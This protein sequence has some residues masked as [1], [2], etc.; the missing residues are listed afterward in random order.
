MTVRGFEGASRPW[1]WL[2]TLATPIRW[3]MD[4]APAKG[5]GRLISTVATAFGYVPGWPSIVILGVPSGGSVA[6]DGTTIIARVAIAQG[7]FEAAELALMTSLCRAGSLAVDVGANVGLFSVA[8]AQA[9]GPHGRVLAIEPYPPSVDALSANVRANR[10]EN[11]TIVAVAAGSAIGSG[12]L[13]PSTDPALV[14]V[15]TESAGNGDSVPITTLDALWASLGQPA[16]SVVKID[17]EGSAASVL[18]GSRALLASGPAVMIEAWSASEYEE[19]TRFM[20]AH[21]FALAEAK[22]EPWNHLF[23][24]VAGDHSG[25]SDPILPAGSP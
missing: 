20:G 18:A 1:Q 15:A 25:P 2:W 19:I 10:L 8:L 13:V 24:R 11:V 16:V 7:Q 17:V 23:R 22:L 9:V 6:V 14:R 3:A 4:H 5:R 21:G 12:L